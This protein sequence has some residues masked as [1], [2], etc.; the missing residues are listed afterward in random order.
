MTPPARGTVLRLKNRTES[1]PLLVIVEYVLDRVIAVIDEKGE[2]HE[3]PTTALAAYGE[4]DVEESS[5]LRK[6]FWPTVSSSTLRND[7]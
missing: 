4:V 6:H 3:L 1:L 5:R 7:S 2:I